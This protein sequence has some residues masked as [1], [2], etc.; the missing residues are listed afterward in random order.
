MDAKGPL[1]GIRVLDLTRALAGP[2][3]TQL[4][5]DM[6]AEV[7]KIENPDG[8]DE[9]R[10]WGPFWDNVSCYFLSANRSKKSVAVDMKSE[11]GREIVVALAKRSDVFIEN[12]RPGTVERL[13]LSYE[14]LA[15]LNPGLVYC[16]VS[17]F[18]QTGPRAQEPA[19]DLLMQAFS[20]LMGLTGYPGWPP[21]RAGLPVTDFG[22]GLF[23]AFAI[24]V[25]LYQRR[26]DGLGQKIE[27]SLL[28]G[29]LSWVSTYLLGYL[30][31]GTVPEGLGSGHHSIT[32]YQAYKAKD[33][34]FILAVGN[35][36][37]WQRLCEAVGAPE[38]AQDPRF[39]TNVERLKHRD[40]QNAILEEI[41]SRYTA[42]ELTQLLSKAGVPCGTINKVDRIVADP[43]VKHLGSL[44]P[45]PHPQVPELQ[46]PGIPFRLSRTPGSI[47]SAP[48]LLG[49]HT[50]QVLTDLG[51]SAEQIADL[52]NKGVIV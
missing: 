52:R 24:M 32:P 48:P 26:Q 27:T 31:D 29:Q 22:A 41:F 39:R 33:E 37:Q 11:A 51:Y 23:A 20:G 50:E 35:D 16:S 21:V 1:G 45:V 12:F 3:C 4:L 47:Q 36:V 5:G 28:E 6:G 25:A 2:F 46:L 30:G 44:Q 19:Y 15:E 14:I 13:G 8:G 7:I 43:Q 18:G 42:V 40:I 10:R 17:G 34:Y 9:A 38:L 49:Q